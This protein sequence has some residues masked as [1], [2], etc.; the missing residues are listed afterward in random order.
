MGYGGTILI[1]QSPHG[2][3]TS[4]IDIK[5]INMEGNRSLTTVPFFR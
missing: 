5:L 1:P 2:E 4:D 3:L